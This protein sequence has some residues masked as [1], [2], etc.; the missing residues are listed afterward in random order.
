ME[1]PEAG[2]PRDPEDTDSSTH[3]VSPSVRVTLQAPVSSGLSA[4]DLA[5]PPNLVAQDLPA[6]NSLPRPSAEQLSDSSHR[7]PVHSSSSGWSMDHLEA[8]GKL[9]LVGLHPSG[10][11]QLSPGSSK[12][13]HFCHAVLTSPSAFI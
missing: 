9:A 5:A 3:L 13:S 1:G 10:S 8:A 11:G 2:C 6:S 7:S 4:L 12:S